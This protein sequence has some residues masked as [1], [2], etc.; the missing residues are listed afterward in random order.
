M[1]DNGL[2]Q[3]LICPVMFEFSHVC[4]LAMV[5]SMQHRIMYFFETTACPAVSG[6][7]VPAA[8]CWWKKC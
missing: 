6:A 2:V 1:L 3:L 5:C 8:A 7:L 4:F